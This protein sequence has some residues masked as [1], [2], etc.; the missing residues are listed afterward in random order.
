M[1]TVELGRDV[2]GIERGAASGV[3]FIGSLRPRLGRIAGIVVSLLVIAGFAFVLLQ[4]AAG[5]PVAHSRVG[6]DPTATPRPRRW[7]PRDRSDR[8]DRRDRDDRSDRDRHRDRG[9]SCP[10]VTPAGLGPGGEPTPGFTV[11]SIP[12]ASVDFG[13]DSGFP[14]LTTDT[15]SPI[16]SA[17]GGCGPHVSFYVTFAISPS[18][19]TPPPQPSYRHY[20]V[21]R[22]RLSVIVT[23]PVTAL[24]RIRTI[25]MI[26][27]P[28]HRHDGVH[29]VA[30]PVYPG[31]RVL[32]GGRGAS[33][34]VQPS[35][36]SYRANFKALCA[37]LAQRGR[38]CPRVRQRITVRLEAIKRS[39]F[40]GM[41]EG[42]SFTPDNT[43]HTVTYFW[44]TSL[45][46]YSRANPLLSHPG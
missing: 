20:R 24:P 28:R 34:S 31:E 22:L 19:T 7:R 43:S 15:G 5:G 33:T 26:P 25:F 1:L 16:P 38:S 14:G 41:L 29:L 32:R 12:S 37:F 30:D 8:D 35:Q 6:D 46:T 3:G 2:G 17:T 23:A 36:I 11:Q 27:G 4:L 21:D 45:T 13:T 40:T 9:A 10:T 39:P 18:R 42:D 44:D